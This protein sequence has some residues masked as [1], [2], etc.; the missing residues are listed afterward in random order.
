MP[1]KNFIF[2][3]CKYTMVDISKE[4]YENN[5]IEVIVDGIGTL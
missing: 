5:D 1:S 3:V 2:F 4:L